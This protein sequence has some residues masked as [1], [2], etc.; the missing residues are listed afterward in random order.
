MDANY[1]ELSA[2]NYK[3]LSA[4]VNRLEKE[5]GG[6]KKMVDE[7]KMNDVRLEQKLKELENQVISVKQDVIT[8]LNDH[9][10]KT[11]ELIHK[12]I[13]VICVLVAIICLMA[14]VKLLPDIC[15]LVGG[16]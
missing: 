5:V 13:K 12:G 6:I 2:A 3:E 7:H 15:T 1:K 9:S 14:G 10:Q 11:W 4:K 16:M 8:T